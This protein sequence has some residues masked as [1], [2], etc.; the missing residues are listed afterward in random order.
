MVWAA[1]RDT[2]PQIMASQKWSRREGA[3]A[4]GMMLDEDEDK[5]APAP[6]LWT[7]S[8]RNN[9]LCSSLFSI[10][11]DFSLTTLL[12]CLPILHHGR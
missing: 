3:A 1:A 6:P 2:A 5:M 11:D 10:N 12:L 9:C 4:A 7:L 8:V